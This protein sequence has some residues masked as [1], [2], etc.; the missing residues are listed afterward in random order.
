MKLAF[1]SSSPLAVL[2]LERLKQQFEISLVV[3]N[4]DRP[5]G[6][7]ALLTPSP[8]KVWAEQNQI[9]FIT[10]KSLKAPEGDVLENKIKKEKIDLS[11]VIDFGLLIPQ[12]IFSSPKYQTIN[13]HFSLLPYYRG[14]FPDAFV[15]LK[16]E[17]KTGISFVLIDEGF[18]TGDLI[19]QQ[20][21]LVKQEETASQLHER[22]Y[23]E[24]RK[25]LP[26]IVNNWAEWLLNKFSEQKN[27]IRPNCKLFLPPKKQDQTKANYTKRLERD[28]GYIS[29]K[30][31]QKVLKKETPVWSEM[32]KLI[33]ENL[34][35]KEMYSV[36][37]IMY[38]FYR[39]LTPWPGMWSLLNLNPS[40]KRLKILEAKLKNGKFAIVKVQI[41][42]KTPMSW[43]QF[44]QA[45]PN[46][47]SLK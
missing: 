31:L 44:V 12:T 20:E 6:R 45:Y 22:L 16:G 36:Q 26:H 33:Q 11:I 3:T 43:G 7:K 27:N 41:E 42:A 23:E 30:T 47:F 21:V 39:A 46:V 37:F 17:E 9:S 10:P 18:D 2:L 34:N 25:I 15:I 14:P 32:P 1:F 13:I 8:L 4:P 28:D 38:N 5:I 19:A 24:T 40:P 35:E 29:W